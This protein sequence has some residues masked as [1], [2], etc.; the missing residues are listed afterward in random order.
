MTRSAAGAAL[1]GLGFPPLPQRMLLYE[2]ELL[3]DSARAL[4]RFWDNEKED[5]HMLDWYFCSLVHIYF[6][7]TEDFVVVVKVN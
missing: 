7:W 2:H 3:R 1:R 5:I 6:N 4:E